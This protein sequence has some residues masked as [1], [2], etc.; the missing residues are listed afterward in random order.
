MQF[1]FFSTQ[2]ISINSNFGEKA[3]FYFWRKHKLKE[4]PI[5][6]LNGTIITVDHKTNERRV[7]FENQT[8][9]SQTIVKLNDNGKIHYIMINKKV[10]IYK[11]I[12]TFTNLLK[13]S[14]SDFRAFFA[15]YK[16]I[17]NFNG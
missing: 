9:P 2:N 17:Y 13:I 12:Y 8:I 3:M 1:S 16:E 14:L 6:E 10:R 11:D 7:V 4:L 5:V 15:Y